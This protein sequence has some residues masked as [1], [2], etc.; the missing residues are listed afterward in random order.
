MSK[1]KSVC[2]A[3]LVCALAVGLPRTGEAKRKRFVTPT[4]SSTVRLTRNDKLDGRT[5][6]FR[7][8]A[9]AFRDA[10]AGGP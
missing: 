10:I 5:E 1:R 7:S 8:D 6:P 2:A 9:D 3:V 4:R